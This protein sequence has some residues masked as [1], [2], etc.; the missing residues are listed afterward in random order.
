MKPPEHVSTTALKRIIIVMLVLAAVL[1]SVSC[2]QA[3]VPDKPYEPDDDGTMILIGD[4]RINVDESLI[5]A[6]SSGL[7]TDDI[8]QL[9]RARAL[10]VLSLD[11]NEIDDISI[12][13]SMTSLESLSVSYNNLT[14][15]EPL[16]GL[17][18]LTWLHLG[19]NQIEDINILRDLTGLEYLILFDNNIKDISPLRDLS[20]LG[21]L[22]LRN[23]AIDDISV[24]FGLTNL[25]YLNLSGNP[26]NKEDFDKLKSTL[27]DC[28]IIGGEVDQP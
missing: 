15:I 9:S 6:K 17:T 23:N 14:D 27:V 26:I 4:L 8:Q 21:H 12:L 10:T 13:S 11:D 3:D 28:N 18:G 25:T 1:A 22:D 19:N 2:Q 20:S 7:T 24:L 16:A 5:E